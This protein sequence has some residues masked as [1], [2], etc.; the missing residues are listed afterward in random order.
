MKTAKA[1]KTKPQKDLKNLPFWVNKNALLVSN[2]F[3]CEDYIATGYC[4]PAI[5]P[6]VNIQALEQFK[7]VSFDI[8]KAHKMIFDLA[9]SG[10]KITYLDWRISERTRAICKAFH[11]CNIHFSKGDGIIY[12]DSYSKGCGKELP[13]DIEETITLDQDFPEDL[14]GTFNC[15]LLWAATQKCTYFN[16]QFN[17]GD[18]KGLSFNNGTNDL[19]SLVAGKKV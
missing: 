10:E 2:I 11:E 8:E 18:A 6:K 3:L 13:H 7:E 5:G 17:I 12:L 19:F 14:E 16:T 15:G 9:Q 1:P 4:V